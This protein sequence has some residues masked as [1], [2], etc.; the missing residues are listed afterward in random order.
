MERVAKEET[1]YLGEGVDVE[2][3]FLHFPLDD[4]FVA[5]VWRRVNESVEEGHGF[6]QEAKRRFRTFVALVGFR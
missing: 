1:P 2:S 3:G 5:Q 6:D 4:D